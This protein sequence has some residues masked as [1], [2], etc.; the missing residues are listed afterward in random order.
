[1]VEI[2]AHPGDGQTSR[3]DH[4]HLIANDV[5]LAE[6]AAQATALE[7]VLWDLQ[8]IPKPLGSGAQPQLGDMV[9]MLTLANNP[10]VSVA[11]SRR[12]T[13]AGKI[14]YLQY[15]NRQIAFEHTDDRDAVHARV[16]KEVTSIIKNA[17]Q[18]V[19]RAIEAWTRGEEVPWPAFS[20]V[21]GQARVPA[22]DQEQGQKILKELN[23][24]W[25]FVVEARLK[26][27]RAEVRL[28]LTE[29]CDP[30]WAPKG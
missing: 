22:Y 27:L 14:I 13:G 26:A 16:A 21:C 8:S 12:N 23:D 28:E 19:Y 15:G 25:A 2:S 17:K 4:H 18:A 3:N 29:V 11:E 7:G 9:A 10:I 20:V 5:R 6:L 24:T 30:E 1:M